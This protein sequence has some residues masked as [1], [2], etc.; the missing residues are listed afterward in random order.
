MKIV[1]LVHHNPRNIQN[2]SQDVK[3]KSEVL[4]DPGPR[5]EIT[6]WLIG[7]H[8]PDRTLLDKKVM[9]LQS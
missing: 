7:T 9:K 1:L 6:V 8:T 2:I 5:H 3:L 4:L